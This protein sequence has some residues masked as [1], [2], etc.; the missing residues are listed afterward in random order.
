MR[1][2]LPAPTFLLGQRR[3]PRKALCA[4]CPPLFRKPGSEEFR[5]F[6]SPPRTEHDPSIAGAGVAVTP[7][8]HH[9]AVENITITPATLVAALVAAV[10]IAVVIAVTAVFVS[11]SVSHSVSRSVS[12]SLG[13]SSEHAAD[14]SQAAVTGYLESQ[15]QALNSRLEQFASTIGEFDARRREESAVIAVKVDDLTASSRAVAEEARAVAGA[16]SDNQARGHWGEM[17]L[18]RVLRLSGLEEHISYNT[19]VS[20]DGGRSRPDALVHLPSGRCVVIDAKT[21]LDSYLAAVSAADPAERDHHFANH[22]RAVGEHI[23]SLASRNYDEVVPGAIDVVIVFLP[24]DSLLAEAYRS[25]PDLLDRALAGR[26]AL[27]SPSTLL[28]HLRGVALGWREQRIADEAQTIAQLGREL[29]HRTSTFVGH[30]SALGAS[31]TR[32]VDA[33]NKAVGSLERSV[34]PQARRFEQLGAGSTRTLP[35]VDPIDQQPRSISA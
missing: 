2:T 26:I 5:P 21:P 7:T 27:A 24:S 34:L 11:R 18:E 9:V 14:R 23:K 31:L 20:V 16:M 28:A 30:V 15:S 1:A 33:Y 22:A 29:H 25:Q 8:R 32:A 10:L 6:P 17:Q 19:Q 35:T 13:Q 3:V 4:Q 12:R